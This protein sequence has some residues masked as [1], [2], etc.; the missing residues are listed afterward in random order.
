MTKSK[1][2]TNPRLM[3]PF[4]L[5]AY[6]GPKTKFASRW[7]QKHITVLTSDEMNRMNEVDTVYYLNQIYNSKTDSATREDARKKLRNI[8]I[9]NYEQEKFNSIAQ[10]LQ[11]QR[12][13]QLQK[14]L[15]ELWL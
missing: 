3:V 13:E 11:E 10:K 15:N 4:Y 2:K 12:L 14:E 5:S 9:T 8:Y 6:K 7:L 1:K